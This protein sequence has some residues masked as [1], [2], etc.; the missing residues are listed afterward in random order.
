MLLNK[1]CSE[2]SL[3]KKLSAYFSCENAIGHHNIRIAHT[4]YNGLICIS[5][6]IEQV[7]NSFNLASL[8][9]SERERLERV[10]T[11][12]IIQCV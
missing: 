9:S 1:Q 12:S 2:K 5:T 10:I 7:L 4:F 8:T 11:V 6:Y 3:V